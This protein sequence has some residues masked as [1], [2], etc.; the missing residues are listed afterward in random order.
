MQRILERYEADETRV[1]PIILRPVDWREAPFSHIQA[2]PTEERPV[3][4][5]RWHDQDEAFADIVLNLRRMIEELNLQS[6]NEQL[7]GQAE[8]R[9]QIKPDKVWMPPKDG[10]R[11]KYDNEVSQTGRPLKHQEPELRTDSSFAPVKPHE[12][13][14]LI[15]EYDGHA[16]WVVAVAWQPGGTHI[17]SAG[18][19][20]T[21]RVWDAMT[22]ESLLTYRRHNHVLNKVNFQATIYTLA[23]NPEGTCIASAGDGARVF[24]WDARTGQT[25]TLYEDHSGLLPN[26]YT[27]VWSPDGKQIASAC[28]STG[29]DKTVHLWDAETGQTLHRYQVGSRWTLSFSVLSVAWSPN[30]QYLVLACGDKIIQ[31]LHTGTGQLAATYPFR[32]K[33]ASHIVWSPDSRYFASA[34]PDHTAVIWDTL[35]RKSVATYR[36]HTEAVRYIAWSPDGQT[37]ATASN[38]RTVQIW[39]ALSGKHIYTYR[40]HSDWTTSVAWSPDGAYIASASNDKTVHIWQA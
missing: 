5:R 36:G 19:D 28:S 33:W 22:G 40:S 30:G 25:L 21:A 29:P 20:G 10:G 37:I 14:T 18:G 2:L 27:A 6:G 39:E 1:I 7:C 16:S 24:V 34:H 12:H 38:D 11:Q 26:V 8:K 9:E 13:G 15:R 3:A 32:S 23:W 17:A 35:T 4:D 31:Q